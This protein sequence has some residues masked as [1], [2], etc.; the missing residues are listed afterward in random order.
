MNIFSVIVVVTGTRDG[1]AS[2]LRMF[3]TRFGLVNGDMY[4]IAVYLR[5]G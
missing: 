5:G 3:S 2:I 4:G 1:R